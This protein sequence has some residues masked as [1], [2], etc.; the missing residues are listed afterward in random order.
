[1]CVYISV[2]KIK[3][4]ITEPTKNKAD[5]SRKEYCATKQNKIP[6][7]AAQIEISAK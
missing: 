1:M 6:K 4:K 7:E 5:F 2:L 3:I